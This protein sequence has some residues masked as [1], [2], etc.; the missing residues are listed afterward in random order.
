MRHAKS[1]NK[2]HNALAARPLNRMEE[3]LYNSVKATKLGIF[4]GLL[5][6]E[7]ASFPRPV[8]SVEDLSPKET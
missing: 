4:P 3:T 1:A 6:E 2:V 5:A 7:A 8:R